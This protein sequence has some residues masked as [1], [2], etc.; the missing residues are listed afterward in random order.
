MDSN[1]ILTRRGFIARLLQAWP[2]RIGF[3]LVVAGF[4][5]LVALGL[6]HG[7]DVVVALAIYFLVVLGIDAVI[8]IL[9]FSSATRSRMVR[10]RELNARYWSYRIKSFFWIG[11]GFLVGP[12]WRAY[13]GPFHFDDFLVPLVLIASGLG[14]M[15]VWRFR[16]RDLEE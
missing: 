10:R 6:W 14:A 16:D 8:E 7:R 5:C 3:A 11:L 15:F 9:P 4:V 13:P 1:E 2:I 12:T